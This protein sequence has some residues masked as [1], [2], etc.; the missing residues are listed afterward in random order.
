[1]FVQELKSQARRVVPSTGKFGMYILPRPGAAKPQHSL[2]CL[3]RPQISGPIERADTTKVECPKYV[4]K[5]YSPLAI[6]RNPERL[7]S[8]YIHRVL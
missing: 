5:S 1:M 7:I 6:L 8:V 2:F 3:R 4:I